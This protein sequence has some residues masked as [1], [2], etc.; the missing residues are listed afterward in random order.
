MENVSNVSSEQ[1]LLQL[2][3]EGKITEEEYEQLLDVMRK[4]SPSPSE[5]PLIPIAKSRSK[6]KWGKTAFVFML[7]GVVLPPIFYLA[8]GM[9]HRQSPNSDF[10][11]AIAL[12]LYFEIIAF[13]LGIIAWPDR[14]AKATVATISVITISL[15]IVLALLFVS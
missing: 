12:G 6:Y 11:V 8:L 1:E 5:G 2:L 3:N 14:F 9:R 7:V 10:A 15:I 4:S 13:V